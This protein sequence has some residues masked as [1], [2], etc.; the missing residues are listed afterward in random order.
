[1]AVELEEITIGA[2]D[3]V[4]HFYEHE[5]H[6]LRAVGRYLSAALENGAV[7]IV[8][9][10]EAH[11]SAFE[12]QLEAG[13]SDLGDCC[14]GGRL[15]FL[16]AAATMAGFVHQG[17]VDREGFRQIVGSVVREAAATGNPVHAYGEMVALLWEAGHVLAAIE[18]EKAWN[19]LACE[20]PFALVCGYRSESVQGDEHADAL[21][22]VCHL[23][24]SALHA[25]PAHDRHSSAS[26]RGLSAHFEPERTAARQAR[27]FVV[28][29]LTRWGHAGGFLEDA[30]LVVTELATNA[31][32]HARSPFSVRLQPQGR[33]VRLAITDTSLSRPTLHDA[34]PL[35]TSGRGLRLVDALA[36]NWGV[37]LATDGK[38]VWAEL[39]P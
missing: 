21:Q 7:A 15:I 13:R 10:T 2:G 28:D 6:L 5:S 9:A 39:Q 36:T 24:S 25:P 32:V 33:G 12:A 8:I 27:H 29:V 16:D 19:E 22:E 4:V 26:R 11:R 38:T 34:G 18:L 30:Q 3:H 14:F 17:E 37:E 35:A 1:M 20:V 31:I 23:H